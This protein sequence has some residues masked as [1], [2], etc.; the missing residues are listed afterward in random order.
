MIEQERPV[1]YMK[2]DSVYDWIKKEYDIAVFFLDDQFR[3]SRSGLPIGS[4]SS[5]FSSLHST[6][7]R[8]ISTHQALQCHMPTKLGCG[9]NVQRLETTLAFIPEVQDY[10]VNSS[11]TTNTERRIDTCAK[12]RR[13]VLCKRVL[14]FQ[15]VK[16]WISHLFLNYVVGGMSPRFLP[17]KPYS[18]Y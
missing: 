8:P 17:C 15:G 4:R 5:S 6:Y 11:T 9:T 3:S 18:D 7:P 1:T 2:V 16:I 14:L 12:Q 10:K 13:M